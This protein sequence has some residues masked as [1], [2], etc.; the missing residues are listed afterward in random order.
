[1]YFCLKYFPSQKYL[2][3]VDE[4][5]IEYKPADR[6]LE[7]FLEKYKEKTIVIDVTETF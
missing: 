1:M 4:L 3:D 2:E 6:T 7:N 5:K